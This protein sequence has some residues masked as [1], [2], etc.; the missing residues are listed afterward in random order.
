MWYAAGIKTDK[1]NCK[2]YLIESKLISGI[3]K[4]IPQIQSTHAHTRKSPLAWAGQGGEIN[5]YL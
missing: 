3:M 4:S 5:T 1:G 2:V